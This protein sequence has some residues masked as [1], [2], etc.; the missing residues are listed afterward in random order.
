MSTVPEVREPR[1]RLGGIILRGLLP[2]LKAIPALL[3]V[4][5][6]IAEHDSRREFLGLTVGLAASGTG[7]PSRARPTATP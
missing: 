3:A 1:L 6:P 5:L 7:A 4:T 2:G